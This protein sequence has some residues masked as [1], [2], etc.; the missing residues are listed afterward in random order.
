M[1][2]TGG[3][4]A[5]LAYEILQSSFQLDI[6]RMFAALFLIT[7]TG[8]LLYGLMVWLQQAVLG[9]WHESAVARER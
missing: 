6:P 4:S 2:G 9:S 1:A 8:V 7:A 3:S 5:G